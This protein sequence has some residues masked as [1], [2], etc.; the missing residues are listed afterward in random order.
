MTANPT[1]AQVM[2]ALG[3]VIEPELHKDLVTALKH[4]RDPGFPPLV[5]VA[6]GPG[7]D[8]LLSVSGRCPWLTQAAPMGVHV[9][10][11]NVLAVPGEV[12]RTAGKAHGREGEQGKGDE[13]YDRHPLRQVAQQADDRLHGSYPV[14]WS[15]PVAFYP[16]QRTGG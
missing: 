12:A 11:L 8:D 13:G 4:V 1:E 16:V 7:A 15:R 6:P 2:E 14:Q 3:H 9:D 10:H 5:G